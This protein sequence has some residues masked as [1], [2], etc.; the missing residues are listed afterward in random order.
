MFLFLSR[1]WKPACFS[2]EPAG[3]VFFFTLISLLLTRVK[4]LLFSASAPFLD[5]HGQSKLYKH[6][7]KGQRK[8]DSFH[9]FTDVRQSRQKC[10]HIHDG[11]KLLCLIITVIPGFFGSLIQDAT[12][13][14]SLSNGLCSLVFRSVSHAARIL[15]SYL[16]CKALSLMGSFI[17]LTFNVITDLSLGLLES[18]ILTGVF[19]LLPVIHYLFPTLG[20]FLLFLFFRILSD[21]FS[22]PGLYIIVIVHFNTIFFN[23][24]TLLLFYT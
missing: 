12:F 19:C 11:K 22:I 8:A 10:W 3:S 21:P 23:C 13:L 18:P 6:Y 20:F 14:S 2:V 4:I 1:R 16:V 17:S 7:K 5:L 24:K 9:W 15:F